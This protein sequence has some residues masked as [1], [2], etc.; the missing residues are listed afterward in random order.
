MTTAERYARTQLFAI[1]FGIVTILIF[2][3]SPSSRPIALWRDFN[4]FYCAGRVVDARMNPY[5]AEPLGTCERTPRTQAFQAGA[6]NLTLPAPLPPYDFV[7]FRFLAFLPYAW[8]GALWMA[9]IAA[10]TLATGRALHRLCG[11]STLAATALCVPTVAFSAGILGE[12]A[13]V[14]IAAIAW[15]A[16]AFARRRSTDAG[17]FALIAMTQPHVGLA[18]V[19]ALFLCDRRTRAVLAG[20]AAVLALWGVANVGP[21]AFVRYFTTVLPAHAIAEIPSTNQIS[22]TALLAEIGAP[23]GFAVFAGAFCYFAMLV[24]GVALAYRIRAAN[25][26]DSLIVALPVAFAL[27]GGI[28][29]HVTQ[30]PAA[31]PCTLIVW[32]RSTGRIRT[33]LGFVAIAIAVPWVQFSFLGLGFPI[34]AGGAMA[35]ASAELLGLRF[36]M[37]FAMATLI[38][39]FIIGLDVGVVVAA[40]TPDPPPLPPIVPT[41]L[42]EVNWA[43][44]MT[45]ISRIDPGLYTVARIPSWIGTLAMVVFCARAGGHP[46]YR[47][48]VD[49]D[50][51]STTRTRF[52][53]AALRRP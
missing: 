18:A 44:A 36:R 13:P 26:R 38:T 29:M 4:A 5:L 3:F 35:V 49:D 2:A 16:H 40:P 34:L 12:M 52:T 46:A 19:V 24:A 15:C 31:L 21:H 42:P 23:H 33:V 50:E 11:L 9:V 41:D 37:A 48:A 8:A 43:T 7:I 25:A 53:T 28:F 51:G 6:E 10:C 27:L 47:G 1:V 39:G 45:N 14:A 22:L 30:L 17:I 32:A 20:G